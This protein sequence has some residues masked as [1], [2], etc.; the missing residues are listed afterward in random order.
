MK[1]EDLELDLFNKPIPLEKCFTHDVLIKRKRMRNKNNPEEKKYTYSVVGN[2]DAVYDYF[3]MHD[4]V[5]LKEN[6]ELTDA[7]NLES[8]NALY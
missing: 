6:S 7:S 5:C 1:D 3:A 4:F 2:I 8:K